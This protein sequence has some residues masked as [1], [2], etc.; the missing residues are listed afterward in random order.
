MKNTGR[1]R[2]ITLATFLVVV[3]FL[4]CAMLFAPVSNTA[5]A[6]V[7]ESPYDESLDW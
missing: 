6:K 4:L 3:S 5:S 2:N 7:V 1:I